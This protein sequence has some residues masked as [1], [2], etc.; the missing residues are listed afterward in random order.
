M[1]CGAQNL[2]WVDFWTAAAC[3]I[4]KPVYNSAVG[5]RLWPHFRKSKLLVYNVCTL[6]RGDY[7]LFNIRQFLGEAQCQDGRDRIN[8]LLGLLPERDNFV[9]LKPDHNIPVEVMYTDIAQRILVKRQSL[10]LLES[11]HPA[12]NALKLPMGTGLVYFFFSVLHSK[13]VECVRVD[14]STSTRRR[15]TYAC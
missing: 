1:H 9:V 8:A 14:F 15:E 12:S 4:K 10:Y 6:G 2:P 5:D 11:C 13:F 3:L 7:N